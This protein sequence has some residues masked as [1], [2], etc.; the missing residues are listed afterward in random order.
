ML[1]PKMEEIGQN[2]RAAIGLTVSNL[3]HLPPS[4]FAEQ[5]FQNPTG[6]LLYITEVASVAVPQRGPFSRHTWVKS[7]STP[8]NLGYII[9]S[10]VSILIKGS[11]FEY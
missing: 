4:T 1:A 9:S 2:L 7:L 11:G 6:C 5:A 8:Y 10:L 3:Y